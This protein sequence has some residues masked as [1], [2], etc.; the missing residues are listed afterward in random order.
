MGNI[1]KVRNVSNYEQYYGLENRH[2]LVSVINY[3]EISPIRPSVNNYEVYGLFLH[4]QLSADLTYGCGR[5]D[6]RGG[7]LICVAPGQIGGTED[8][9]E[10]IQLDGWSLLFHPDLLHGTSLAK[11]IHEYTFF[12]YRINEALH[13]M[14][15]EH[16][17]FV[18]LLH[19]IKH[20]LNGKHDIF[21]NRILTEY[22]SLLLNYCMRFYDRQFV[23]RKLDNI[24]ILQRFNTFLY[25]YFNKKQQLSDGLP[26]VQYCADHLC[27]SP[28]YFGDLIK[29]TTGD[30]A[31]NYIYRYV[32]QLA[33][34]EL[35][36]GT[37]IA[38][39]AYEMGFD[40]PQHFTRMFRQQT[41]M[42]PSEY[43]KSLQR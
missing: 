13:L 1:L 5:Y 36:S 39:V 4:N 43:C 32:I 14:D 35:A 30:N 40:Y 41:G 10:L 31:R 37:P 8:K 29:K 22:I 23:T 34:N 21:Q 18:S 17:I 6:Y 2:P 9:G 11:S 19:Q 12:D 25:D 33:K 42:T 24:D 28:N 20:E 27:L 15:E 26:S 7:T 16:D 38:Q 3:A